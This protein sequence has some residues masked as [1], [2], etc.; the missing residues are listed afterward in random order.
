MSQR[1]NLKKILLN[2][3]LN[4]NENTAYQNLWNSV[5]T[6]LREKFMTLNAYF[7]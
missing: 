7:R 3:E 6:V 1:R 2:A 4:K 5:K